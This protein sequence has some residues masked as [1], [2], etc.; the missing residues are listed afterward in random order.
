MLNILSK[1][2]VAERASIDEAYVD[3]T[4]AAQQLIADARKRAAAGGGGGAGPDG[5]A[6][7]VVPQPA[8]FEG[9]HVAGVVSLCGVWSGRCLGCD[10]LGGSWSSK[11]LQCSDKIH[12]C[13]H[14]VRYAV[15][16]YHSCYH[17]CEHSTRSQKGPRL[18]L[19]GGLA[20]LQSGLT[21]TCC[22]PQAVL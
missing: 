16:C 8:S 1:S 13:S 21:A 17:T 18:S 5:S 7:V 19:P 3:C 20:L 6:A 2:G 9:V 15:L 11:C 4:A 14:A 12:A 22:L 10:V